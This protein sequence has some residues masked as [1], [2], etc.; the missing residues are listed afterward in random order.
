MSLPLRRSRPRI[1]KI[2]EDKGGEEGGKTWWEEGKD[3]RTPDFA[4]TT[5]QMA[6]RGPR[7]L[8]LHAFLSPQTH[9]DLLGGIW[10]EA[11]YGVMKQIPEV[12]KNKQRLSFLYISRLERRSRGTHSAWVHRS[13]I[14]QEESHAVFTRIAP[15]TSKQTHALAELSHLNGLTWVHF[16]SVPFLVLHPTAVAVCRHPEGSGWKWCY[17][18]WDYFPKLWNV[19]FGCF[20]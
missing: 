6:T 4:E 14:L 1:D 20:E 11:K 18:E 5:A 3:R 13:V 17:L 7:S 12:R 19:S 10:R 8:W 2:V 15:V 16:W 9:A